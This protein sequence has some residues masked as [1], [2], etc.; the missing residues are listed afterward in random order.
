MIDRSFLEKLEEMGKT[1][2]ITVGERPYST[3]PIHAVL[4]PQ[5]KPI[6][7]R[8]LS[9]ISKYLK[10]NVDGLTLA[11]LIVHILTPEKVSLH[12]C[13]DTPFELRNCYMD[14]SPDLRKFQFGTYWQVE[15]FII[16]MQTFFVQSEATAQIIKLVGNLSHVAETNFND[17]GVTQKVTA[18]TGITRVAEIAVPSPVVLAPFRTF[19]EVEQPSSKFIFRI[20]GREGTP[21]T[22]ALFEADG[23]RWELEAISN[24]SKWLE[25]NLPEEITILA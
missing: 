4:D 13:L 19:L 7:V 5:P 12:S 22:C 17:D 8:T 20:Q 24:I 2:I 10:A 14:A 11:D 16:A 1:E 18:K 3:N 6:Q 23:G 21:P 15:Q 9:A 25:E